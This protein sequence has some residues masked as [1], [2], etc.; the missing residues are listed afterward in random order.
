MRTDGFYRRVRHY[1]YD[2]CACQQRQQIK[3]PLPFES[4]NPE[5]LSLPYSV[6]SSE[7]FPVKGIM[8]IL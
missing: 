4:G 6:I 7:I 8:Q 2:P 1:E 5:K 3:L